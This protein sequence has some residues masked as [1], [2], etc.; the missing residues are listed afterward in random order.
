METLS[1]DSVNIPLH[2][3]TSQ[4]MRLYFT[5]NYA[6]MEKLDVHPGQVPLLLQ[7]HRHGGMRQKELVG[8]LMVKPPTV[9]VMI[10]RMEKSGFIQRKQDEPGSAGFPYLSD[11]TRGGNLPPAA[12]GLK[13]V[14][15]E[16]FADFTEE[17]IAGSIRLFNRVRE[18]L[19]T[20]CRHT[21]QLPCCELTE[22]GGTDA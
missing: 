6:L 21:T 20:A 8:K 9:T 1:D 22:R 16:C 12:E 7:L 14:E 4:I 17:E 5:R 3:L 10:K 13:I 11:R 18:N 19:E 2:I 15:A